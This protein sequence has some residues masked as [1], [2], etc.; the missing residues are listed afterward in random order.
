MAGRQTNR[1]ADSRSIGRSVGRSVVRS[2]GRSVVRSFAFARTRSRPS[3]YRHR[4][5][6]GAFIF[7]VVPSLARPRRSRRRRHR[8]RRRRR[9]V[10]PARPSRRCRRL[11]LRRVLPDRR[12]ALRARAMK[13]QRESLT[14]AR[15]DRDR[16]RA[17]GEAS[18][19]RSTRPRA[20]ATILRARARASRRDEAMYAT[21]RTTH[22]CLSRGHHPRNLSR[23]LAGIGDVARATRRDATD[24]RRINRPRDRDRVP[25][26]GV[27]VE[28]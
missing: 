20:R 27:G 22:R 6:D 15:I 16:R 26:V 14:H 23:P 11:R 2:F 12:R 18:T 4:G 3:R 17:R 7:T 25:R 9:R 19:N 8:H 28:S 13:C 10:P 1:Q 24:S 21:Y 5:V